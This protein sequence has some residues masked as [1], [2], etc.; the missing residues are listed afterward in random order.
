MIQFSR[1]QGKWSSSQGLKGSDPVLKVSR[2]VVQFSRS[3][4]KWSSSQ[5]LKG[6]GPVLKVSREVVSGLIVGMKA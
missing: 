3:Q 6:S 4:G 1:S 2:E 5:G